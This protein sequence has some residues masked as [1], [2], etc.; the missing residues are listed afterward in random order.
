[1]ILQQEKLPSL[2]INASG[3][4]QLHADWLLQPEKIPA[5]S[6]ESTAW[7][8]AVQNW[9]PN[10]GSKWRI[11][12]AS[13]SGYS[14]SDEWIVAEVTSAPAA[15]SST[16]TF[17]VGITAVPGDRVTVNKLTGTKEIMTAQGEH[18]RSASWLVS[19]NALGDWLPVTGDQLPWAGG[20]F[21]CREITLKET[22][23]MQWQV[24]ISAVDLAV[25]PPQ[26]I[27]FRRN[28]DFETEK[29]GVWRVH[30]KEL[31]S[32]KKINDINASAPWAG[33]SYRITDI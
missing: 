25:E 19:E 1:M 23:P 2:N 29:Y 6:A 8:Q 5:N 22:A 21:I 18:F 9:L 7:Q 27:S 33:N 12:A 20:N 28:H 3:S 14:E 30:E 11:P 4:W 13:A 10:P 16:C 31:E 17:R 26:E 24:D 15:G 32:F